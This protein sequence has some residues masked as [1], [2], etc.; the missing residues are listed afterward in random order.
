MTRARTPVI[1]NSDREAVL[2][3]LREAAGVPA[4]VMSASFVGFGSMVHDA[5]W[6]LVQGIVNTLL[7][8]ALPGQIAVVEMFNAG[9]PLLAITISVGLINARLFPMV[10]SLL[11][12]VRRPGVPRWAYYLVAQIIAVTSW[13]GVM[14]RVPDLAQERR[15]PYLVGYGSLLFTLSPIFMTI[16][17]LAAGWVPRPIS[18]G[19]VFL[20]P[21][22]FALLFLLDIRKPSKIIALGL[23]AVMGPLFFLAVADWSLLL[24]GLIGGTIAYMAGAKMER[25][26]G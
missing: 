9:A 26:H 14:S 20:N 12:V 17:F 15:F 6:T 8:W 2:L 16:G 4:M 21:L 23:G 18:I 24:T 22:Y 1:C 11:P 19:L 25:R 13:M 7:T 10:V 3:G 5:G